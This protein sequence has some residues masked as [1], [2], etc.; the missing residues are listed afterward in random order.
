M[1]IDRQP[2]QSTTVVADNGHRWARDP[3]DCD[4]QYLS[5]DSSV[6][7]LLWFTMTVDAHFLAA[8]VAAKFSLF[9]IFH[10]GCKHVHTS[11]IP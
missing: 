6:A 8:V 2:T 11:S 5:T 7:N 9:S 1:A 4:G 3:I 10:P